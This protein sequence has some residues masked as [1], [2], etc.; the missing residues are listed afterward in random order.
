MIKPIIPEFSHKVRSAL[1]LEKD[2]IQHQVQFHPTE[3]LSF[4]TVAKPAGLGQL[5]L[6]KLIEKINSLI[7]RMDFG[8]NNGSTG[9][10]FH[11]FRIGLEYS[12]VVYIVV[13]KNYVPKM[14]PA[15]WMKLVAQIRAVA[16]KFKADEYKVDIEPACLTFRLWWD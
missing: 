4:A 11:K 10:P 3:A 6:V 9:D 14:T 13:P 1:D 8:P 5:E 16:T 15:D 12:R 7:P 2:S